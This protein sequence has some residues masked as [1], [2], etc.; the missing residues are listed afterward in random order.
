VIVRIVPKF[1]PYQLMRHLFEMHDC[2]RLHPG[3]SLMPGFCSAAPQRPGQL[4]TWP[5]LY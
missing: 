5:F 4:C 2:G 1:P 3:R